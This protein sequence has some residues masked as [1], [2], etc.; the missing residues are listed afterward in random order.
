MLKTVEFTE[1]EVAEPAD[2][3]AISQYSREGGEAIVGGAIAY[4]HHWAGYSIAQSSA[5]EVTLNPGYLFVDEKVYGNDVAIVV[6]LQVYLPLVTGDGRYVALLLRGTETTENESR[7]I[8]TDADTGDTVIQ[9]VPKTTIR[10]VEVVIQQG[11]S[12]PT[13]VK[14]TVASTECCV[15]YVELST[16]GIVAVEMDQSSRVKTLSEVEGRLT[17]VENEMDAA[18]ARVS[19]I[20]TDISNIASRLNDIPNPVVVRQMQRDLAQIRREIAMPDEAR[21]YWYDN[22]LLTDE[23]DTAN[24][25]WLA[26]I[27][28]GVRFAW[29]SQRD[30][31][32]A[33]LDASSSAIRASGT[34]IL[35]AWEEVVRLEVEGDG[36]SK[37]ISQLTHTVTTAI[38][39][40]LSRTVTEYGATTTKCENATG[41][42]FLGNLSV[43]ETFT[44]SGETFVITGITG[45]RSGHKSYSFQNITIRTVEE[46]YWDYVTEEMGVNGS[47]YGQTWLCAQPMV[48][49]GLDLSFTRVGSDGEVHLFICECDSSGQPQLGS[50]IASTTL[51]AAQIATGWVKFDLTPTLLESGTRYAWFTV[52]TGN[53][54]LETVTGNK[55]AQGSLFYCT[56]GVWA[57]GDPETDFAMRLYGA[58]F[59]AT[60]TVVEMQSATLENGMTDIRILHAGWAPGGTSLTWEIMPAD[61][62]D[63]LPVTI[64]TAIDTA[65]LA[66]LPALTRLRAVFAGT[67]DLQPAIVM[68]ANARVMTFRPRGDLQA[69]SVQ[70][71]FGVS[72]TSIQLDTVIDQW[73]GAK[74]TAAP[75]L[76][77]GSTVYTPAATIVTPDLIDEKKRLISATFTVPS[78][79]SARARFD[80]A[81]TEVTDLPFIDNIAMYA[82]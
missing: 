34:L 35:P 20:E 30:M 75:K 48:L 32:M 3:D 77:V 59:S 7:E 38:Q 61:N 64:D 18:V 76:V 23:W 68:D 49:T 36:G 72:T 39:K 37:N 56:D 74:H 24:A 73:D 69:V 13:P 40:T 43:G 65:W 9:T 22:G 53:H 66:G 19:S 51:T 70:H 16:T 52:T 67:T 81:T 21:A 79:T 12:S 14:P 58:K 8:E 4:A 28:E 11:L 33:L 60:R 44:K 15:A 78:T 82:L 71:D 57:Q 42:S 1:A 27:R 41:W 6:N 47:I 50:V 26:R 62:D 54:A 25:S 2:F 63:W 31:Q 80:M 17:V 46:N 45:S 5:V 29:A 10:S 55:Y